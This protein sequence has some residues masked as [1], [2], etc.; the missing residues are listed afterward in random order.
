MRDWWKPIVGV[1]LIMLALLY[2]KPAQ[3]QEYVVLT[4][5]S[6]HLDRKQDYNEQNWGL[7]YEY[8]F[9]DEWSFSTGFYRNSFRRDTVYVFGAHTPWQI[10][11]W[12][13][14]PLFGVVTGYD[15]DTSFSPWITGVATK[16]WGR[17]GLNV[18]LAPAAIALQ[19]KWR[20]E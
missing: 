11:G 8:K 7:G 1:C 16:E 15:E 9:S 17:F 5:R 14:G 12:R 2:Y 20:L 19:V 3:C 4:L 6:Y 13:F 18:V 10:A